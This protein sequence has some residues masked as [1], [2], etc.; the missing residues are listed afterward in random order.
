LQPS[1]AEGHASTSRCLTLLG[2]ASI[3]PSWCKRTLSQEHQA[4]PLVDETS[5]SHMP[6]LSQLFL[7]FGLSP[8]ELAN[9]S[10]SGIAASK[11]HVYNIFFIEDARGSPWVPEQRGFVIPYGIKSVIGFGGMLPSGDFFAMVL[12]ARAQTERHTAEMFKSIALSLR[13]AILRFDQKRR[14]WLGGES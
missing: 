9:P 3:K 7:Q 8:D 2:T 12:F 4:I 1:L 10:A 11:P 6:M 5:I 14:L 13:L